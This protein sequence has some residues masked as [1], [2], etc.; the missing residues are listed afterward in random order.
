MGRSVPQCGFSNTCVQI[1]SMS[2]VPFETVNIL[3]DDLLRSGMKEYSQW[4]TFPQVYIAG[5]F[6][7]GCDIMI[8]S[9]QKGELPELSLDWPFAPVRGCRQDITTTSLWRSEQEAVTHLPRLRTPINIIAIYLHQAASHSQRRSR[10]WLA[11]AAVTVASVAL[12]SPPG[13]AQADGERPSSLA[14]VDTQI[15]D[16]VFLDVGMCSTMFRVDRK[17][18]DKSILCNEPDPTGRI[19]IGLYGKAVPNTVKNFLSLV[20]A[21]SL[22]GTTF[23]KVVP[24]SYIQGGRQGSL[25]M[26][27]VQP[28][29]DL[30]TNPET[31]SSESFRLEHTRPGTVSLSLSEND[32]EPLIKQRPQYRNTEFLITT[33]PG[34]ATF[35]DGQNVVFGRVLSGIDTVTTVANV[36][37]FKIR[38]AKSSEE[39]WQAAQ[40]RAQAFYV[41]PPERAFA[42][43]LHQAVM[44]KEELQ[45][46]MERSE[47]T[48]TCLL[49]FRAEPDQHA[50]APDRSDGSDGSEV[51][52]AVGTLDVVLQASLAREVLRGRTTRPAYLAN[53]CVADVARRRGVASSMLTAARQLACS[54]EVDGLFVH[55]MA[56]NAG[57]R[58][59]YEQHGFVL[60][61]EESS[62]R[63][64]YRGR[65]AALGVTLSHVCLEAA[66]K[67]ADHE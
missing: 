17:M 54:W 1:L 16:K 15:T 22:A 37:T 62:N 4:P 19:V 40:L 61:Q 12:R 39:L 30:P 57:A 53:L 36:P 11:S 51:V 43:K 42:G 21:Q 25:R 60:D 65:T 5:E 26:G 13:K 18:G 63:A 44:A 29:Y 45:Y 6:F 52:N 38:P 50:D 35:L 64:H 10:R 47:D 46:L 49:A 9:F 66:E 41:Y 2:K 3:E 55:M 8:E 20:Q 32:D 67:P 27:E 48:S 56:A 58:A 28:P 7:G 33:G 24:G 59:F 34:P 31:L 23:H 14:P